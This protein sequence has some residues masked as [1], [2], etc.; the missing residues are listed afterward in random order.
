MTHWHPRTMHV[1]V[2]NLGAAI[3][4]KQL[5]VSAVLRESPTGKYNINLIK[6]NL[7]ASL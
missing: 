7:P 6:Q 3:Q 4:T 1:P 5:D 2:S